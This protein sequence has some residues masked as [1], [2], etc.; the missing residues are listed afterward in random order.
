MVRRWQK[1]VTVE[2]ETVKGGDEAYVLRRDFEVSFEE[3][4]SPGLVRIGSFLGVDTGDLIECHA[5]VVDLET[6]LRVHARSLHKETSVLYDAWRWYEL[7]RPWET[8]LVRVSFLCRVTGRNWTVFTKRWNP[9]TA[10]FHGQVVL[11]WQ[12]PTA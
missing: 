10:I 5:E 7:K 2:P 1:V 11:E 4:T 12:E 6:G 3:G 8:R 9:L